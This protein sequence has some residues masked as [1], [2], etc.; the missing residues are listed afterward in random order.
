M[1]NEK[2]VPLIEK[3]E[4]LLGFDQAN[5]QTSKKRQILEGN[6]NLQVSLAQNG[7]PSWCAALPSCGHPGSAKTPPGTEGIG[8]L[9]QIY[10]FLNCL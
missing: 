2:D 9:P 1:V 3:T 7:T 6:I 5:H 8:T 10:S 4:Y